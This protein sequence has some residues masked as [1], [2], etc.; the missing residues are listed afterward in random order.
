M[1]IPPFP[2]DEDALLASVFG[3][4]N[5]RGRTVMCTAGV[6]VPGRDWNAL[7]L[8]DAEGNLFFLERA[9]RNGE[10]ETLRIAPLDQALWTDAVI[11]LLS[12]KGA[13]GD[14]NHWMSVLA[15]LKADPA[16]W[17]PDRE[18][19]VFDRLEA[20]L[21][22]REAE[23]ESL[24]RSLRAELDSC[25]DKA[26]ENGREAAGDPALVEAF[27]PEPLAGKTVVWTLVDLH[28]PKPW[29]GCV[30]M[31]DDGTPYV[32]EISTN[33]A[34]RPAAV[35]DR[36]DQASWRRMA[37]LAHSR[38]ATTGDPRYVPAAQDVG[39]VHLALD[40]ALTKD[41]SEPWYGMGAYI[42]SVVEGVSEAL[43]QRD[44]G[45]RPH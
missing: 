27:G 13:I 23:A 20:A 19:E 16:R 18:D 41:P 32:A 4:D 45:L 35:L 10:T 24:R 22:T 31:E 43:A 14:V 29:R 3:R 40:P 36:L 39:L 30:L 12:T 6:A 8:A 42:E 17:N 2:A 25:I 34:G 38:L 9:T 7:V 33:A 1:R 37:A 11:R 28:G 21:A 15:T 5:V 44:A 26:I